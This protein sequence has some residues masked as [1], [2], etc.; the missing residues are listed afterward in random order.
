M[1]CSIQS[2]CLGRLDDFCYE[3]GCTSLSNVVVVVVL[4]SCVRFGCRNFWFVFK[5]HGNLLKKKELWIYQT[6]FQGLQGN[7][8]I[9]K[10][11]FGHEEL[12]LVVVQ[13]L[14]PLCQVQYHPKIAKG[15][16]KSLSLK[17]C[18]LYRTGGTELVPACQMMLKSLKSQN[19]MSPVQLGFF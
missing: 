5:L 19:L 3:F 16:K 6:W 1:T 8:F 4:L 11:C 15:W 2:E 14:L 9:N 7:V 17:F 18:R 10:L 12:L 13:L